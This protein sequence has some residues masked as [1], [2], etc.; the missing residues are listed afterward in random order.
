MET[1]R[2]CVIKVTWSRL[3]NDAIFSTVDSSPKPI[4]SALKSPIG[5]KST[6]ARKTRSVSIVVPGQRRSREQLYDP[7]D[8]ILLDPS[9][10]AT[11]DDNHK[12]MSPLQEKPPLPLELPPNF[13]RQKLLEKSKS[14]AIM[15]EQ[16][17][18]A[19]LDRARSVGDI[20]LP[21]MKKRTKPVTL[22]N[23]RTKKV[24]EDRLIN[25]NIKV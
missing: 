25:T 1:T 11:H 14:L 3:I 18:I 21:S 2:V 9:K 19:P 24:L 23:Y 15:K 16:H 17:S 20:E 4:P 8:I 13:N 7:D 22:H 6:K 12:P 10:A 5:G